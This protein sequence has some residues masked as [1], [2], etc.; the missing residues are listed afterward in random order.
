VTVLWVMLLVFPVMGFASCVWALVDVLA[1]PRALLRVAGV[2]VAKRAF[3]FAVILAALAMCG[4]LMGL[5]GHGRMVG[6]ACFFIGEP[7]GLIGL[8]VATWY[9]TVVR[10]WVSAQLRFAELRSTEG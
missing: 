1:R 9:L 10:G 4:A 6:L 5:G 8:A 3:W 7:L 2:S